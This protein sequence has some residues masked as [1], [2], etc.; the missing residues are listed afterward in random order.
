[1]KFEWDEAKSKETKID[2]GLDFNDARDIW[3]DEDSV[4]M[5]ARSETEPRWAKIGFTKGAVHTAIF[6]IRNNKIR[7]ISVRR[8]HPN[9]EK[10]YEQSK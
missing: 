9:E 6:T 2:R 8:A 7:I 10:I 5:I 4:E 1:M 3:N